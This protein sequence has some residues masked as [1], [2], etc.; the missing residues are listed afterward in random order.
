MHN[1]V[2]AEGSGLWD[3]LRA[4]QL[5]PKDGLL[6]GVCAAFGDATHSPAWLWRV[7]FIASMYYFG[8]GFGAYIVLALCIPEA[9]RVRRTAAGAS[10]VLSSSNGS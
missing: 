7:G 1:H 5:N 10:S 9:P 8:A 3:R 6:T 2:E 4:L